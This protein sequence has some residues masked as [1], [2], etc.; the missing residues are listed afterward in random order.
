MFLVSCDLELLCLRTAKVAHQRH[1][2]CILSHHRLL[3]RVVTSGGR[4]AASSF[5]SFFIVASW[6]IVFIIPTDLL[7]APPVFSCMSVS[8]QLGIPLHNIT[9]TANAAA[10]V[11]SSARIAAVFL[12][13]AR[14]SRSCCAPRFSLLLFVRLSMPVHLSAGVL[15][16][17]VDRLMA[18]YGAP[19]SCSS[20]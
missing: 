10:V 6:V 15:L 19:L 5:V 14:L 12:L 13:S 1:I 8:R 2:K 16:L 11:R 20:G 17:I 18:D 9:F 4:C 3:L 7:F